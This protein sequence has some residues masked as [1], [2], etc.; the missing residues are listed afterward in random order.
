MEGEEVLGKEV[1]D[2]VTGYRGI[3]TAVTK[4]LY[5]CIRVNVAQKVKKDGTIPETQG[6]DLDQIEVIGDGLCKKQKAI[7]KD[8]LGGPKP[9]QSQHPTLRR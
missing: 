2:K 1:R 6:F 4:W 8:P 7:K 9:L 5:G 3:V